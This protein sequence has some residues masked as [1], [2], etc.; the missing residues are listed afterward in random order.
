MALID[1]LL[2]EFAKENFGDK[3]GHY[4][5]VVHGRTQDIKLF[6]LVVRKSRYVLERPFKRYTY[7]VVAGLEHY[8][9]NGKREEYEAL[10]NKKV[11]KHNEMA[12]VEESEDGSGAASS[13]A[14]GVQAANIANIQIKINED[15]GSLELGGIDQ[16]YI[17]DPDL[18]DV[19]A[20]TE[21]DINKTEVFE[22][23]Q[24]RLITSVIYSQQF[25][26]KGNRKNEVET[27]AGINIPGYVLSQIKGTYK[28]VTIPPNIATRANTRGPILFQCC[29][30]VL[31]KD[32]NRLE[33]PKGEFV[34]K[35]VNRGKEE[36]E[37][38]KNTAVSLVGDME[39]SL[40][41]SFT[42]E[43]ST[44]LE[45]I[46]TSV[47]KPTKNREER[48]E[49]VK[50]YL[51]WVEADAGI[52][53]PLHF[54][55][56]MKGKYINVT[57]PPNIATRTDKRGPILFQGCRVV[58]N[59]DKNRLEL[60]KGEFV[61]KPVNRCKEDEEEDYK[62]TAVSLVGDM[63]SSFIERGWGSDPPPPPPRVSDGPLDQPGD[64][65]TNEDSTKLEEITTSVLKPTKNR[66]ER[67]GRVKKYLQWFEEAM[68]TTPTDDK[69]VL[70]LDKPLN[71]A[72]CEFLR[73]I[74]VPAMKNDSTFSF[75]KFFDEEKLQGYAI[76]LKIISDLSEETWDEIEKVWAEKDEAS[77]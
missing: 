26:V 38:Y 9:A 39:S 18:R 11:Q 2:R 4:L 57:I 49:R 3:E 21:L 22:D 72:D 17:L 5:P 53:I 73:T 23:Q 45:E 66:E 68:S 51:Q 48:K 74:F 31:N 27:D 60:P 58:L 65:F 61:G 34:G 7:T 19:L 46:T 30:V 8:V 55:S 67:K 28:N 56:Q 47:L 25:A 69:R 44:K 35:P 75:P 14:V 1:K 15:L 64:S 59:K 54:L 33:L 16:E 63:E 29:R 32:K 41:D 13:F 10:K 76:V 40:I 70:T 52:N 6:T 50:K 42:N 77:E 36:E 37:E 12:S 43:D 24:L 71:D 62:N 20:K